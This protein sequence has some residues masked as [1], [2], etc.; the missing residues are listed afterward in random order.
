MMTS[1]ASMTSGFDAEG[2]GGTARLHAHESDDVAVRI[3]EPRGLRGSH[4]VHVAVPRH[5]REV[6]VLE[7]DPFALERGHGLVEAATE[8]PVEGGRLVGPRVLRA[9]D[10]EPR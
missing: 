8:V 2:E 3:F 5:A 1:M 10:D 4:D 9:V 7:G 6:V